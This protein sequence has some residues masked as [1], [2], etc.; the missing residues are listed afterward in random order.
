MRRSRSSRSPSLRRGSATSTAA[1]IPS[2]C[3]KPLFHQLRSRLTRQARVHPRLARSPRARLRRT[4][5]PQAPPKPL[6]RMS[7]AGASAAGARGRQPSSPA[8]LASHAPSHTAGDPPPCAWW[9]W[10]SSLP[11]MRGLFPSH[12][13][14]PN[15]SPPHHMRRA[16]SS[17][18]ACVQSPA[19]GGLRF[20]WKMCL[21]Q[22]GSVSPKGKA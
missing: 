21:I 13:H 18:A 5:S 4:R 22:K 19:R 15:G 1:G 16:A 7:S 9:G 11:A 10:R 6:A 12:M 17:S 8:A 20:T 2:S 14:H 3:P